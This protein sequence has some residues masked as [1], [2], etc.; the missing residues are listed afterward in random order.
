[1]LRVRFELTRVSPAAHRTTALDH[2][3]IEAIT[4]NIDVIIASERLFDSV[5]EQI[6]LLLTLIEQV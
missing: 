1:M 5:L 3:A 2:S 4:E 6:S